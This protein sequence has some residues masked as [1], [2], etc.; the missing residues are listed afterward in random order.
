MFK[1]LFLNTCQF[2][3][4]STLRWAIQD[5]W[6]SG[7]YYL[8][9]NNVFIWAID[10]LI[11]MLC[12]VTYKCDWHKHFRFHRYPLIQAKFYLEKYIPLANISY[13]FFLGYGNRALNSIFRCFSCGKYIFFYD[14][15]LI[16]E[17]TSNRKFGFMV[18]FWRP[19]LVK[20]C[21]KYVL[22]ICVFLYIN[23]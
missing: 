8:D 21:I 9:N 12:H 3:I 1:L 15:F 4:S 7:L 10:H 18:K 16:S 14:I 23:D 20:L 11:T 6:S 2:N 13:K 17:G 22:I 5:Q 19:F